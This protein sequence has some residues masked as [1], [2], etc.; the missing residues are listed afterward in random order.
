M[1]ER[2]LERRH[3]LAT[4]LTDALAVDGGLKMSEANVCKRGVT[5]HGENNEG[6][7]SSVSRGL[8]AANSALLMQRI[9]LS[10][11]TLHSPAS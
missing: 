2:N 10:A 9:T 7:R 11:A 6:G 4:H 1:D 8:S 3:I 5:I